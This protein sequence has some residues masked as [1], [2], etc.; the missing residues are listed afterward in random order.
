MARMMQP[1]AYSLSD[2][3]LSGDDDDVVLDGSDD[4][5]DDGSFISSLST[6]SYQKDSLITPSSALLN[7]NDSYCGPPEPDFQPP[8]DSVEEFG[9]SQILFSCPCRLNTFAQRN[10]LWYHVNSS[11]IAKRHFPPVPFL[12]ITGELFVPWTLA[13]GVHIVALR[14]QV[15]NDN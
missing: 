11:H 13:A 14:L 6:A 12:K 10:Y 4:G 8:M 1:C 9:M 2:D 5:S 7:S 3:S 15:V